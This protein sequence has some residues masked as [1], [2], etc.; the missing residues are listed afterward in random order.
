MSIIV[1]RNI[2]FIDSNEFFKGSL[3]ILPSNLE[4]TDFKYLVLKFPIGK[5]EILK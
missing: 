3:D 2:T 4:D 1:K 5:L